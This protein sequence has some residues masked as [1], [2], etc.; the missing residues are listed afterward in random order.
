[1]SGTY[2]AHHGLA[3]TAAFVSFATVDTNLSLPQG[4]PFL[5][6]NFIYS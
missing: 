4:V 5:R 3:C 2:F 1:M 6:Q